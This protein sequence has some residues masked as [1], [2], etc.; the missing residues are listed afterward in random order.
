[1]SEVYYIQDVAKKL[2]MTEAAVRAHMQRDSGA[3]PLAF[4]LGKK[5]AWSRE[6]FDTWLDHRSDNPVRKVGRPRNR[7]N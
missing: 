2:G 7:S 6:K 4:K 1:M 3:L 5:W